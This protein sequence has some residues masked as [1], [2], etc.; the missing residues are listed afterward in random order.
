MKKFALTCIAFAAVSA[1]AEGLAI[2]YDHAL[3]GI[4]GIS[5]KLDANQLALQGIVGFDYSSETDKQDALGLAVRALFPMGQRDNLSLQGGVGMTVMG[6]SDPKT[7]NKFSFEVPFVAQYKFSKNFGISTQLG[8]AVDA[9]DG[10]KLATN[11]SLLG[12][13]GFHVFF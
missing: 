13:A 2:G 5:A 3:T 10:F 9:T 6:Y 4:S 8:F 12:N 7:K 1:S 11:G